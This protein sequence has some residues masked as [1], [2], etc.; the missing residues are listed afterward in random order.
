MN[1]TFSVEAAEVL[2]SPYFSHRSVKQEEW[3]AREKEHTQLFDAVGKCET[4]DNLTG[5]PKSIYDRAKYA[6]VVYQD[7]SVPGER[8]YEEQGFAINVQKE[9]FADPKKLTP[10]ESRLLAAGIA[11]AVS[12]GDHEA[13]DYIASLADDPGS[14]WEIMQATPAIYGKET[15]Q[16][17]NAPSKSN[18]TDSNKPKL[19]SP[20]VKPSPFLSKHAS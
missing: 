12:Q 16:P 5:E 4:Y 14:L 13:A 9:D 1:P 20:E 19:D 8:I 11:E 7:D 6:I 10:D 18:K 15:P 17:K 2:H 3:P